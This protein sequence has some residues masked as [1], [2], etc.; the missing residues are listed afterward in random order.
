MRHWSEDYIG[1]PYRRGEYD[2]AS[3]AVE[4]LRDVFNRDIPDYGERHHMMVEQ[5]AALGEEL[6]RRTK[7]LK[8][9]YEGC[10]V[11]VSISNR[12]RH[13]GVYCVIDR[14]PWVLHNIRRY[15]AI[16]TRVKDMPKFGWRIEG[17]YE[18]T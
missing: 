9:P 11:Q 18:W 10:L 13:I 4:V 12:I 5:Y 6:A 16:I 1:K 2:C 15:G 14:E 17:Y 7:R 8:S 3:L